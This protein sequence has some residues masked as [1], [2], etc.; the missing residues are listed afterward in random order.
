[1]IWVTISIAK[2]TDYNLYKTV[3]D[4]DI[5]MFKW[6]RENVGE[7]FNIDDFYRYCRGEGWRIYGYDSEY[8]SVIFDNEVSEE[9]I[10]M[11]KLRWL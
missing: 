4:P 3:S 5:P 7:I 6:L 8:F 10:T 9:L 11:F 2:A 1:M